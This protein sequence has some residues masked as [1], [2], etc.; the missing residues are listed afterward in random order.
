MNYFLLEIKYLDQSTGKCCI[1]EMNFNSL[2][3]LTAALNHMLNYRLSEQ[4]EV[5]GYSVY[6]WKKELIKSWNRYT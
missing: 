6:E 5:V 3:S 1:T 2:D 4:G